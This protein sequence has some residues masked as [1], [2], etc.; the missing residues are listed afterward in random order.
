MTTADFSNQSLEKYL[1]AYTSA[2]QTTAMACGLKC[3]DYLKPSDE[4]SVRQKYP[5]IFETPKAPLACYG[6]VLGKVKGKLPS[7]EVL[8]PLFEAYTQLI[9]YLFEHRACIDNEGTCLD[10][11]LTYDALIQG[12]TSHQ[13]LLYGIER[14]LDNGAGLP[15]ETRRQVADLAGQTFS[16]YQAPGSQG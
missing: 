15:D 1:T 11:K 10:G 14:K 3:G 6:Q 5:E 8:Q 7:P 12:V 4:H 13:P 16:T 9:A 2:I